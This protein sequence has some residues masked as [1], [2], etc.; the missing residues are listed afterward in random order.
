MAVDLFTAI[1]RG[2]VKAVWIMGT[3]PAVS[4]PDSH[5]VSQALAACLLVIVSEV[6]AETDTSHYADIRFPALA[7][8]EKNGTVT[9]SERRISR[10]RPFLP[11]PGEARADWWIIAQVAGKLGFA[12]H[13]AWQ[14]PHEVFSEHAALSGLRTTASGRSISGVGLRALPVRSGMRW[15]R[16]VGRLAVVKANGIFIAAWRTDGRL[17]MVPTVTPA[18]AMQARSE[19]LSA[20]SQQR[21]RT[22]SVA[23]H[24]PN[25]Q[26]TAADAAYRAADGGNFATGCRPLCDTARRPGADQLTARRDGG[27]RRGERYA[28]PGLA[29]YADALE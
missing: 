19:P 1:G 20:D 14:H 17:R 16:C 11:P 24:D 7:W 25:R 10:Q 5:A 9:N 26:R 29:V 12:R 13:S 23:H 22:R 27:S 6:A 2:D 15:R 28:A 3:N 8:G 4:L 18:E 21:A